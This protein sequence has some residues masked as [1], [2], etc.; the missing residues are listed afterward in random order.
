M[1]LLKWLCLPALII[2]TR[3]DM[4]ENIWCYYTSGTVKKTNETMAQE[5]VDAWWV[6]PGW[7]SSII[8]GQQLVLCQPQ[9]FQHIV[10][11][12]ICLGSSW[13]ICLIYKIL[14][15]TQLIELLEKAHN[16]YISEMILLWIYY[17]TWLDISYNFVNIKSYSW[18]CRYRT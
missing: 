18:P 9:R 4:G 15:S 13:L 16:I 7:F 2:P 1:C 8:Q 6:A 10:M 11:K 3:N 5:A 12:S 14:T 17:Y